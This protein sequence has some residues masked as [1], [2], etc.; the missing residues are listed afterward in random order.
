MK[1]DHDSKLRAAAMKFSTIHKRHIL[2]QQALQ[3]ISRDAEAAAAQ[4]AG[5]ETELREFVGPN[6]RELLVAIPGTGQAVS[7]RHR[8]GAPAVVHLQEL[9]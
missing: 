4:L 2:A 1:P 7:I 9:L 3:D 5:A 6:R 8:E